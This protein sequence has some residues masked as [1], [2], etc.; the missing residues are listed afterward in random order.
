MR[1]M[2]RN[3]RTFY[4]A[5]LTSAV[6]GTDLDGNYTEEKY[7]YSD[8]V[9][10][11]GVFTPASGI[12]SPQL[13]GMNEVY[14]KA[15]TLNKGETYLAVGSVLWVDTPI[16]LDNQGHLARD[17]DGNV[18]T[19]PNYYV[20]GVSESLNFVNVAIRKVNVS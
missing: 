19:P 18:L 10:A 13:F 11:Y 7:T 3:R 20:V 2:T 6:M 9:K 8:P 12:A 15:I 17:N 1:T 14:D 4:Y 5:S 16:S